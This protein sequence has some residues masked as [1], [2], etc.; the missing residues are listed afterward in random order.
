M[1]SSSQKAGPLCLEPDQSLLQRGE[2]WL[3]PSIF[4][5]VG[6]PPAPGGEEPLGGIRAVQVPLQHP[7]E[8]VVSIL[9]DL[10]GLG[11]LSC[12]EA[13]EVVESIPSIR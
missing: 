2:V 8:G 1:V 11:P 6:Q 9:V 10:V 3:L 7:P 4:A 13:H 5:L 12:I